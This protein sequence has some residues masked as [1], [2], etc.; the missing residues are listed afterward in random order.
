ME[1]SIAQWKEDKKNKILSQEI[2]PT[3]NHQITKSQAN[4]TS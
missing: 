3:P 4:Q 2:E 1:K